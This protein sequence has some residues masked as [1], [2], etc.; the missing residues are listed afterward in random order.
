MRTL[1][2]REIEQ[3]SGISK[4]GAQAQQ[5]RAHVS[6]LYDVFNSDSQDEKKNNNSSACVDLQGRFFFISF[7]YTRFQLVIKDLGWLFLLIF[8]NL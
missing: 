4:R 5:P 8:H 2:Q 7:W 6:N 3:Q 1:V